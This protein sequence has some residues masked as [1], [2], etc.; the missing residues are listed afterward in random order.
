MQY[1]LGGLI[2]RIHLGVA[3]LEASGR[4][5]AAA[6][7][8][9]SRELTGEGERYFEADDLFVSADGPPTRGLHLACQANSRAEVDRFPRRDARRRRE[10]QRRA[11]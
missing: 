7:E 5:D 10:G 8:A 6:L 9:L 2:D 11:R 3:G 1:H 4:F